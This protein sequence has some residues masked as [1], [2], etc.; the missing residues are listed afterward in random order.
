MLLIDAHEPADIINQVKTQFPDSQV[1]ELGKSSGDAL[2]QGENG[3]AIFERKTPSDLAASIADQRL[4]E[5]SEQIPR[6]CRW[7]FLVIEGSLAWNE[8]DYLMVWARGQWQDTNWPRESV[9]MA[10]LRVQANG[11]MLIE[12]GPLPYALRLKKL[13]EWC[14]DKAD[15]SYLTRSEQFNLNPF[16][17]SAV[18]RQRL[19]FFGHLPEVGLSKAEALLDFYGKET[20]L[21]DLL[22]QVV[23]LPA[24][25]KQRPRL[26][27][28][29]T[30]A[31]IRQLLELMP[32]EKLFTE[33]EPTYNGGKHAQT[34]K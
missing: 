27:G 17:Y 3:T 25:E 12:T 20:R 24:K 31:G 4:F 15:K 33:K 13:V 29:K 19:D 7:P 8:N 16:K 14:K 5:Q 2:W 10:L 30:V 11:M 6:I 1:V 23:N 34:K 32:D 18:L 26:W 9:T 21:I 28:E 22:M